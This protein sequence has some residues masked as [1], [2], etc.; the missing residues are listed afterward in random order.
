LTPGLQGFDCLMN[1]S[2]K[3]QQCFINHDPKLVFNY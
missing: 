2:R 3:T 1:L